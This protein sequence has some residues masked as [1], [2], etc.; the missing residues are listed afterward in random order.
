MRATP[1]ATAYTQAVATVPEP[2]VLLRKEIEHPHPLTGI[3]RSWIAVFGLILV[4]GRD[5][6]ERGFESIKEMGPFMW[7]ILGLV[8]AVV[9]FNLVW[10]II[11]WRTTT[12]IADDEEFRIERDFLSRDSSRI[13]YAK[14]QSVDIERS[15]PA[16][17]LGLSSVTIDVGGAGGKKLEFLA[18][19]RAEVLRDQLLARMRGLT[20]AATTDDDGTAVV[21]APPAVPPHTVVRVS[22]VTLVK[23]VLISSF[24]P[25]LL[26]ALAFLVGMLWLGEGF[27]IAGLGAVVFGVG[28]YLWAQIVSNWNFH[29]DKVPD[30]LHMTRGLFTTQSQSLRADR[31]QAVSIHQ[32]YLQRLTGLYR[33]R[34]TVLGLHGGE[35]GAQTSGTVLP[36]GTRD[37]VTRVL[38]AFWPG[39]NL[40]A[41][42]L[43]GQPSRARWLTPLGFKRHLWGAD[44]QTVVAHHGWLDHTIT[45]VPHR[46]MQSLGISQGPWQ[47]KLNLATVALHTTDGPVSLSLYHLDASDARGF[48]DAQRERACAA[49]NDTAEPGYLAALPAP[50]ADEFISRP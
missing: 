18:K 31:I 41:I 25:W 44:D 28:G 1:E 24:L 3:A 33:V 15:L 42:P 50:A 32:D 11:E 23:G 17:L 4:F 20:T 19:Q 8:L 29:L 45:L 47:R 22:P 40:D 21:T 14:I 30:G 27:T 36:Y 2:V 10:G 39:I 43:H 37:D 6:A 16:R 12:F 46:R 13:S 49:R 7:I 35:G 48:F 34:V 9:L 26:G 38:G 5:I